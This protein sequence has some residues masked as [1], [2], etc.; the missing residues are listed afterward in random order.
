MCYF[1]C[2]CL[3][4]CGGVSVK[5]IKQK[6]H[7]QRRDIIYNSQIHEEKIL[8]YWI[9]CYYKRQ[10]LIDSSQIIKNC[11]C[12]QCTTNKSTRDKREHEDYDKK[13]YSCSFGSLEKYKD[14]TDLDDF[15]LFM[16]W[17][18]LMNILWLKSSCLP[19][20]N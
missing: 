2:G 3:V 18:I 17:R 4:N 20:T 6:T 19:P 13:C 7:S 11:C 8:I 1:Y 15:S 14:E 16:F 12:L 9:W 10:K 5:I